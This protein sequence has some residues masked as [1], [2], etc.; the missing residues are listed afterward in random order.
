MALPRL[1][2]VGQRGSSGRVMTGSVSDMSAGG[3]DGGDHDDGSNCPLLQPLS[4][5]EKSLLM[6]VAKP[7][8]DGTFGWPT[9]NY[10]DLSFRQRTGREAGPVVAGMPWVQLSDSLGIYRLLW[11]SDIVS[12]GTAPQDPRMKVGLTVAG[13]SRIAGA[14]SPTDALLT[15]YLA[16]LRGLHVKL[17]SS[18]PDPSGVVETAMSLND[19]V[20]NIRH[21]GVWA[22]GLDPYELIEDLVRREPAT[23][24]SSFEDAQA[25]LRISACIPLG[26]FAS[27]EK[28]AEYVEE[29]VRTQG[30]QAV[31]AAERR[32]PLDLTDALGRLALAMRAATRVHLWEAYPIDYPASLAVDPHSSSEYHGKLVALGTL[33]E[34]MNPPKLPS[35]SAETKSLGRLQAFLAEFLD[36]GHEAEVQRAVGQLRD[37]VALRNGIAH[38]GDDAAKS[39]AKASRRIGLPTAIGDYPAAFDLIAQTVIEA[40]RS[41][42]NLVIEADRQGRRIPSSGAG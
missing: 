9:W 26:H 8:R 18:S 40:S 41:I 23:S 14:P 13:M 33:F 1:S 15:S 5:D 36:P 24:I 42:A 37:I 11:F 28:P 34:S 25:G 2:E 22:P 3:H 12:A 27:V 6:L 19:F 4:P 35:T 32:R 29:L 38:A 17:A 39:A 21:R 10:I 20:T 30:A 31:A 7:L 16:I